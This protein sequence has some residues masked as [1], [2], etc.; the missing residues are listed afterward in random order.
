MNY[1]Y[2]LEFL[3]VIMPIFVSL[4]TNIHPSY[5]DMF[6]HMVYSPATV[7]G[8]CAWQGLVC[9]LQHEL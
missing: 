2:N 8:K 5:L 6:V 7:Q 3:C 1:N 9:C 4:V